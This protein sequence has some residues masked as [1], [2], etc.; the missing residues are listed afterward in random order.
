MFTSHHQ[1]AGQNHRP[2]TNIVNKSFENAI[3]D[4]YLETA[5]IKQN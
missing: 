1:N 2:N 3:W 5:V 4:K